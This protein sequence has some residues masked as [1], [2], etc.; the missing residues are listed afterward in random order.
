[1]AIFE[2]S[3]V[4]EVADGTGFNLIEAQE[5][6]DSLF[7]GNGELVPGH[8]LMGQEIEPVVYSIAITRL[9]GLPAKPTGRK[10]PRRKRKRT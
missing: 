6:L 10:P 3:M 5:W 8:P 4:F 1:M 9:V 2:I 7:H